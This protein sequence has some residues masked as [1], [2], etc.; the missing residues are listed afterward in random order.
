MH[1]VGGEEYRQQKFAETNVSGSIES[2]C[3]SAS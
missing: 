3:V 2:F 1:G